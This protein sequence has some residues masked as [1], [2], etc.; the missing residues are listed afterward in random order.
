MVAGQV[1]HVIVATHLQAEEICRLIKRRGDAKATALVHS[2]RIIE[3][4]A[5]AHL[6]IININDD[7]I[8][9]G[10]EGDIVASGGK[11]EADVRMALAAVQVPQCTSH[12]FLSDPD[13]FLRGTAI[14]R[15]G[16][17][18]TLPLNYC[19]AFVS[20][21]GGTGRTTLAMDTAFHYAH[22]MS[23]RSRKKQE[24]EVGSSPVLLIEMTYGVSAQMALTGLDMPSLSQLATDPEMRGQDYRGVSFLPMDYDFAR[25][26]PADLLQ[27]Y[28]RRQMERHRLTVIDCIWPHGLSS[29]VKEHVDLWIVVASDRPDTTVNAQ[30]LH[31]E[32]VAE[33]QENKV[34]LIQNQGP[35]GRQS[36][37]TSQ[38]A[39]NIRLPRVSRADEYRGELGRAILSE[40]FSPL[41]QEHEKSAK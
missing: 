35:E 37:D 14:N 22:I 36:K 6:V 41:W 15:P 9:A 5:D 1:M 38:L 40:V 26:L 21:S 16:R 30:R 8:S 31:D 19:I 2:H 34:W 13:R 25:L 39:W 29:A 7:T 23:P 18:L 10:I 4:L 27:R 28:L 17:M 11:T 32:L 12:E 3:S 33:L 24:S 20:Y